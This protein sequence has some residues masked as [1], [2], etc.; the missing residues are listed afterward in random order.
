MQPNKSLY[1]ARRFLGKIFRKSDILFGSR[2]YRH[3]HNLTDYTQKRVVGSYIGWLGHKNFGDDLCVEMIAKL[4][5]Q[6][7]LIWSNAELPIELLAYKHLVKGSNLFNFSILGGGTIIFGK[8][9]YAEVENQLT[10]KRKIYSF[11]SGVRD[12]DFWNDGEKVLGSQQPDINAWIKLLNKFDRV[13][14]R[15]PRSAKILN[16]L[17]VKEVEVIGD[18]ALLISRFYEGPLKIGKTVAINLHGGKGKKKGSNSKFIKKMVI[19]CNFLIS[20][21]YE[22]EF[23]AMEKTDE[24]VINKLLSHL[25]QTNTHIFKGY[26]SV[27]KTLKKMSR[28]HFMIGE[29]LHAVVASVAMGIPCISIAY[30]PKCFDF[31]ESVAQDNYVLLRED[32]T[33]RELIEKFTELGLNYSNISRYLKEKSY[34]FCDKQ[35]RLANY[36][37]KN[38]NDEKEI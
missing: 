21:S 12:L 6:I 30:R 18:P 3:L 14:V 38:L 9:Y 16:G 35:E 31:M 32:I 10:S 36:I 17:G 37:I 15:G 34:E 33:S 1:S 11:G 27:E 20:Q 24:I 26:E 5:G 23:I 22:L 25:P 7:P 4:F 29:R 13:T 28:C 19:F 8:T 2:K